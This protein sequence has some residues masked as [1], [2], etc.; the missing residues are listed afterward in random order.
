MRAAQLG[1]W[2]WGA[3]AL[4]ADF[5]DRDT[6]AYVAI[7]NASIW[8]AADWIVGM[9]RGGKSKPGRVDQRNCVAGGDIVGGDIIR[10]GGPPRMAK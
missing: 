5:H 6:L 3:I 9:L 1:F 7:T 8:A 4:L 10:R 2:L